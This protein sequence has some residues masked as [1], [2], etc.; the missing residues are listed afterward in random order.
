MTELPIERCLE[1]IDPAIR[2]ILESCL[3]GAE[4]TWQD[5][6]SLCGVTGS[7]LSALCLVADHLRR[8]QVGE[9]V[10]YVVNRN[11]N[12]TNVCIKTCRFC[13]FSR[14]LRAE[15][16][17]FLDQSEVVRRAVEASELG[18]TE[19]CLQ[20]GLAPSVKG[21]VYPDLCRAIKAVLPDI[22]IHAFSPEEIKYGSGLARCS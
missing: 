1:T 6:V 5:G 19:V 21:Q 11:I 3:A 13:A 7:E 2:A 14:K 16:G 8:S 4:L 10:G 9:Q 20:A 22:H 12:F 15:D 17:Y 18:A